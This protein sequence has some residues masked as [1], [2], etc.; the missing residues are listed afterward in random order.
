MNRLLVLK[1]LVTKF[2]GLVNN[3]FSD[4]LYVGLYNDSGVLKELTVFE[5]DFILVMF[6]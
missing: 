2:K 6:K 4:I 3:S 5:F 1:G